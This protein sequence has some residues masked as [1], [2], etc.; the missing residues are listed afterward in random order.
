MHFKRTICVLT[1]CLLTLYALAQKKDNTRYGKISPEDF[2]NTRFELDTGAHA[3]VL[4]DI[5]SSNFEPEHER[6]R[7][8]YKRLC[9]V[10]ILDKTGYE[11]A[12]RSIYLYHKGAEEEKVSALKAATYNLENGKVVTTDMDDNSV[13]TQDLDKNHRVQKFTLPA[14]KEGSIIEFTYTITSPFIFNLQPWAF[15]GEYPELWSEYSVGIPQF[16][17]Y[18]FIAQ[19]FYKLES[20]PRTDALKTF[21]FDYAKEGP[22]GGTLESERVTVTA[23]VSTYRWIARDVP[24]LKEEGFTTTLGNHITRID[25]Q[26][27]ATKSAEGEVKPVMATWS[28]LAQDMMKD[29]DYGAALDKN[30]GYMG[31][32]VS[33]LTAGAASDK[34]KARNIY[35]YVRNN[36]TCTDH[37]A[38]YLD[39]PLKT[40]FT[41]RNGNI[42][43]IN[44]LLVAML[45]KAGLTA[46][47]VLLSTRSNGYATQYPM[48]TRF[49]YTIARVELAADTVYLDAA[50]PLGFGRLHASCYNGAAHVLDT[51][52]TAVRFNPDSLQSQQ[53]TSIF[54]VAGDGGMKGTYQQWLGYKDSYDLRNEVF[55]TGKDAYFK[56]LSKTYSRLSNQEINNLDSLETTANVKFDFEWQPGNDD[57]L[58]FNPMMG[59]G[60][61]ANPFKASQRLYPVEMPGKTDHTYVL[62]MDIPSGYEVEEMPKSAM[63]KL[64]EKDGLFQYFIDKVG[65]GIQLRCRIKLDR[66]Y[67][68]PEE[69]ENLR[70]FYDLIVKKQSE[71]IVLKKKQ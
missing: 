14:V 41:S 12:N 31:D 66:T 6:F 38:L 21:G 8:V 7:L 71:Q 35:Y 60:I 64:N 44:L 46:Y 54:L 17:D 27:S 70:S 37:S 68:P 51:A 53:T 30:N 49:N 22:Y 43:D 67:F 5:G 48:V 56:S 63:A 15:Q 18:I 61:Q 36:Y 25:F 50:H 39:K 10:K 26:L 19:G 40:V 47:P 2:K 57:I 34:D 9:R 28:K 1:G 3:V 4:A 69:Y 62:Q 23:N 42:T 52:G 29:D 58:Y 20:K 65:N 33:T 32:V 45:R 11:A 13:F 16:Y 55:S 59:Q 24:A